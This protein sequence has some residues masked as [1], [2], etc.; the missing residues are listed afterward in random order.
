MTG[1]GKPHVPRSWHAS[2][3]DMPAAPATPNSSAG[4]LSP[5]TAA[6]PLR[7]QHPNR[8]RHACRA[9][10]SVK[11]GM[12][13]SVDNHR[14]QTLVSLPDAMLLSLAQSGRE[15]PL[16]KVHRLHLSVEHPDNPHRVF[17]TLEAGPFP[18]PSSGLRP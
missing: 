8:A 16:F 7:S 5:P 15:V 6:F 4:R 9:R 2:R 14:F 18:N 13:D 12:S 17:R 11:G 10:P 3:L 1:S